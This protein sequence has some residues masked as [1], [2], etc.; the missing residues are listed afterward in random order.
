MNHAI[1][2]E[3][4]AQKGKV[5]TLPVVDAAFIE[6]AKSYKAE[7]SP[8]TDKVKAARAAKSLAKIFADIKSKTL[9]KLMFAELKAPQLRAIDDLYKMIHGEKEAA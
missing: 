3:V 5:K 9:R 1:K 2:R 8:A 4:A 7:T 6:A